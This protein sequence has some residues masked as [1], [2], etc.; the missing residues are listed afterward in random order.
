ME[1][2]DAASGALNSG[3]V[4][5][6]RCKTS[7]LTVMWWLDE[8]ASLNPQSF[9][10]STGPTVLECGQMQE[11]KIGKRSVSKNTTLSDLWTASVAAA[12]SA[13]QKELEARQLKDGSVQMDTSLM[14]DV[15]PEQQQQKSSRI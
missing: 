10:P 7:T 1:T 15:A 11:I 3:W 13:E 9:P 14:S 5:S 12:A 4:F 6:S 8:V 2:M